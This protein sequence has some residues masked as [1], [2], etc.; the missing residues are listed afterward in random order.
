MYS[1]ELNAQRLRVTAK[2]RSL[3]IYKLLIIA[4]LANKIKQKFSA[5][6]NLM[7]TALLYRTLEKIHT[8]LLSEFQL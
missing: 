5:N 7:G 3:L 6:F 8:V 2:L 4:N 1:S